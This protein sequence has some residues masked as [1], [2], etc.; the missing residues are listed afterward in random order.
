VNKPPSPDVAKLLAD[1]QPQ[2]TFNAARRA[3]AKR[4]GRLPTSS[5]PIVEALLDAAASDPAPAVRRAAL[6]SLHSPAHADLWQEQADLRAR[7]LSIPSPDESRSPV[8]GWTLEYDL[9]RLAWI[10]G[11]CYC[12]LYPRPGRCRSYAGLRARGGLEGHPVEI[13]SVRPNRS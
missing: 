11:I 13:L 1:L 10:S 5:R 9:F 12:C 4:L 3:A 6:A 7:V 8:S 2:Q